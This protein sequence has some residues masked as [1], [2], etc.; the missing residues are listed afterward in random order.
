M[1]VMQAQGFICFAQKGEI[2]K[3]AVQ[4]GGHQNCFFAAGTGR[5]GTAESDDIVELALHGG[6]KKS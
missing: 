4:Q 1:T 5:S 6:S 2:C 3:V